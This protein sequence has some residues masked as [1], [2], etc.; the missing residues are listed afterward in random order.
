MI[1]YHL[2]A[3]LA[4]ASLSTAASAETWGIREG[5]C[6]DWVGEWNIT[7]NHDNVWFGTINQRHNGSSCVSANGELLAGN[8]TASIV[9]ASFTARQSGMSNGYDC[10]FTGAVSG[11]QIVGTY[12]CPDINSPLDFSISR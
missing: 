1:V 6:G 10:V 8:V 5:A 4:F 3:M 11:S 9:G 2:F 7:K 12:V